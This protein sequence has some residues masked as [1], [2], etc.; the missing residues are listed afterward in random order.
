M[1]KFGELYLWLQ[2]IRDQDKLFTNNNLVEP[3]KAIQ[4]Q[5][6]LF[7]A[8]SLVENAKCY[9]QYLIKEDA[10]ANAVSIRL[11]EIEPCIFFTIE[12][13]IQYPGCLYKQARGS[14]EIFPETQKIWV[15]WHYGGNTM[16]AFNLS[17]LQKLLDVFDQARK[18]LAKDIL[19]DFKEK[20]H[21]SDFYKK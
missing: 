12:Q 9:N 14:I 15:R 21:R 4:S 5:G 20:T 19:L 2:Y 3:T 11:R 16:R 1:L 8:Q 18:P 6:K 10:K 7:N 13:W 17:E